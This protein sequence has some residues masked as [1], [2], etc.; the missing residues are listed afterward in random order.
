MQVLRA[1]LTGILTTAA[2]CVSSAPGFTSEVEPPGPC[3][4]KTP[5]AITEIMYRP[6]P[7]TNGFELEFIEIYN[8]NPFFEDISG[9]RISGEIDY[10]FPPNTVLQGGEFRVIARNPADMQSAYG[11]S[12][13]L[14]PYAKTLPQSGTLRLRN[15]EGAV[16]LEIEYSNQPPWPAAADGA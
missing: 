11:I 3:S 14:G 8:S 7:D 1:L 13:I 5:F 6:M 9:Y 15:K 4:R 12:S 10:T 16:L 2:L